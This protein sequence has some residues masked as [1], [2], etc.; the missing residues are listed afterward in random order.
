MTKCAL[1][2]E[3]RDLKSRNLGLCDCFGIDL[4]ILI[5]WGILIGEQVLYIMGMV[6]ELLKGT[7]AVWGFERGDLCMLWIVSVGWFW[8]FQRLGKA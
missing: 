3:L 7:T 5:G 1:D 4:E 8:R 6:A 2:L